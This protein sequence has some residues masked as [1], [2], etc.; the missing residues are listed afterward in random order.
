MASILAGCSSVSQPQS[1]SE[2]PSQSQS[3]PPVQSHPLV[4]PSATPTGN[5]EDFTN[6]AVKFNS[7]VGLP[8]FETTTDEVNLTVT[9]A[10]ADATAALDRIGKLSPIEVNFTN[11]VRALDDLGYVLSTADNRLSVIQQTSTNAAVR[12]ATTDALKDLEAWMV[13]IDYRDDVYHAIKAYAD[14]HPKLEGEDAKLLFETMRDYRR[15][16]LDLPRS[17]RDE[18]E[19]MRKELSNVS[20]DFEENVTKATKAVKFTKAE[21]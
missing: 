13:S 8:T 18:V 16:G 19:R 15:A 6:R 2:P 17:Q 14:T 20:Q 12:D 9:N 4:V 7:V 3:Q 10:I 21:L 11:T 1:Q 5:L